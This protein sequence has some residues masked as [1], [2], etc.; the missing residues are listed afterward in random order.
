MS[1]NEFKNVFIKLRTEKEMTQDSISKELGVSKSTIGMWETGK[2]LPS[3]DLCEQ[4]ADYFNVDIDYLYGR[5]K[6]RQK[7]H[8]DNDGNLLRALS[9]NES[10]LIDNFQKL[11]SVGKQ[12][13][14]EYITDLTEQSKY[15][16]AGFDEEICSA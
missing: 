15:T 10:S 3:P 1:I 13:A 16:E 9:V 11:N 7:I 5:T 14:M 8:F 2:R 4:I 6:I 12:K